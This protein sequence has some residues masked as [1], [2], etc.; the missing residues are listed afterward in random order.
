MPISPELF[1]DLTAAGGQNYPTIPQ[2]ALEYD[3]DYH[4]FINESD[5]TTL[6]LFWSFS[7]KAGE[8]H[9]SVVRGLLPALTI[10]TRCRRVWLRRADVAFAGDAIMHVLSGSVK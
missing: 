1:I 4:T 3:P 9:G 6:R 10:E 7:G 5:D 2:I 8:D